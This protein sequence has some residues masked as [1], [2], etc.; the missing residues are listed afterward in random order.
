MASD[1]ASDLQA[2]LIDEVARFVAESPANRLVD[3]DGAPIFESP[4]V[5]FADGDGP[6][7]VEYKKPGIVGEFHRTPREALAETIGATPESFARV[8]VVSWV[9]PISETTRLSNAAMTE[10][11]SRRWNNT[12]FQGEAFNDAVRR[13]VVEW[14]AARDLPAVAPMLAPWF[15]TRTLAN[16]PASNWSERHVAYACGL[17]SFG[18]SDA[19]ITAR[20]VAHRCGSVVV[21]TALAPSPRPAGD[22]HANCLYFRSGSCGVCASR[23]PAGAIGPE[24]H[25][26]LKCREHIMVTQIDWLKRPGYI[27]SYPGCGLCVTGVPCAD[28][29]PR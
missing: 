15:G 12:R 19:F 8:G 26:K 13:H 29:I 28:E 14:L 18:L 16:G 2:L 4:L 23:C 7:F 5:G 9:L 22:H 20:G 17:G 27:G 21:A 24:G 3:I 6:L 1:T 11:P 25:D 10:G